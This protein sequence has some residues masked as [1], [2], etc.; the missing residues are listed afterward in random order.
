LTYDVR[1]L[2]KFE[3]QACTLCLVFINTKDSNF[4]KQ[5]LGVSL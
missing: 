3:L 2:S 5:I 1:L 4:L